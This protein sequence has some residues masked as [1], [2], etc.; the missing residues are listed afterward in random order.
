MYS[1]FDSPTRT[2]RLQ[3]ENKRLHDSLVEKN[4]E[5]QEKYE[6]IT[7][8]RKLLLERESEI[9]QHRKLCKQFLPDS[10]DPETG[11]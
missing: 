10:L 1:L 7:T 9:L 6:E 4:L 3:E 5:L 11:Q 2:Q 8:A